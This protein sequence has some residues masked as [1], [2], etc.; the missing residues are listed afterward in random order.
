MRVAS[1]KLPPCVL[2]LENPVNDDLSQLG[3]GVA[4]NLVT[5]AA[6]AVYRWGRSWIA[7]AIGESVPTANAKAEENALA[8]ARELDARLGHLELLPHLGSETLRD[9]VRAALE[10][11]DLVATIHQGVLIGARTSS[12]E[13]HQ[14]LASVIAERLRAK[15]DTSKATAGNLAV[16]AV[17]HLGADHLQILGLLALVHVA[18]PDLGSES[19]EASEAIDGPEASKIRNARS[20][21]RGDRFVEWLSRSLQVHGLP[22]NVD[23]GAL[24]HLSAAACLIVD[25]SAELTLEKALRP[26]DELGEPHRYFNSHRHYGAA[27][28]N[29]LDG[30][31]GAV[32]GPKLRQL[33]WNSLQHAIPTPSGL[34][35]GLAV[36]DARTGESE[37][38]K[39]EWATTEWKAGHDRPNLDALMGKDF[40]AAVWEAVEAKARRE[41]SAGGVLPWDIYGHMRR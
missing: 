10:D 37:V 34:L 24:R 9:T 13:R 6:K 19:D 25:S 36:H 41:H 35:I 4:G 12:R 17:Q 21:E 39:W 5:E 38:N 40:D 23:E 31:E 33:W 2:E 3:M 30:R 18:R 8:L 22:A 28:L 16:T 29:F 20:T 7:D 32:V 1:R 14:I 26:S 11:P 15:T 27:L